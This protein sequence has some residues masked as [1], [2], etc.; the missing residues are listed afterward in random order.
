MHYGQQR[1]LTSASNPSIGRCCAGRCGGSLWIAA[2]R[3]A[4]LPQAAAPAAAAP[5]AAGR[6]RGRLCTAH[7][8]SRRGC[9]RAP[10]APC[11]TQG[12][13]REAHTCLGTSRQAVGLAAAAK[14]GAACCHLKDNCSNG[15]PVELQWRYGEPHLPCATGVTSCQSARGSGGEMRPAAS[16][17][18][19]APGSV[20]G[21]GAE[22]G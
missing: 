8:G 1:R 11:G 9:C 19:S 13:R 12:E 14:R 22:R 16:A 2:P 21:P 15:R 4:P 6:R 5:S 7:Q 10:G 17:A 18:G 3:Q 20:K